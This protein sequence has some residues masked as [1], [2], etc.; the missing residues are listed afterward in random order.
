MQRARIPRSA[1]FARAVPGRYRLPR[2]SQWRDVLGVNLSDSGSLFRTPE[3][4]TRITLFEMIVNTPMQLGN[5][6][7]DR[8]RC[9]ARITRTEPRLTSD[10]GDGVADEFVEFRVDDSADA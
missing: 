2:G 8:F 4:L 1:R 9:I 10:D 5:L 3:P 6:A 7:P